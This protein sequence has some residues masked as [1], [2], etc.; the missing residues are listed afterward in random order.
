M[1]TTVSEIVVHARVA[2]VGARDGH[3]VVQVYVSPSARIQDKRL[4]SYRKTLAGFCKVWVPAGEQRD[5]A[6]PV[7]SEELRWYDE[8]EGQWQLDRGQYKC[9]VGTSVCDIDCELIFDV[10]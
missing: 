8:Q 2:N 5:V 4:V 9:F 7:K 1:T 10:E 3:E 6:I